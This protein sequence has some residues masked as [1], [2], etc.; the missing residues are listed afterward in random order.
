MEYIY[1]VAAQQLYGVDIPTGPLPMRALRNTDFQEVTLEVSLC[2][3]HLLSPHTDQL[4]SL[5]VC[6]VAG[7]HMLLS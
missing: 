2:L 6:A 3:T 5:F 1:R 7:Y 4:D